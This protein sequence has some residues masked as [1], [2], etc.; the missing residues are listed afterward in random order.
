LTS[1]KFFI[2]F[3]QIK[4]KLANYMTRV[5]PNH[6][7]GSISEYRTVINGHEVQVFFENYE[8]EGLSFLKN[9]WIVTKN[10]G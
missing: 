5:F 10:K 8:K 7:F 6:P 2:I 9:G 3:P 4:L 1:A